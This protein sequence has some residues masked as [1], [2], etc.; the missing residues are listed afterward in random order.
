MSAL[1]APYIAPVV[2]LWECDTGFAE[3]ISPD[4]AAW[5]AAAD[6][7]IAHE[8][9]REVTL[10]VCPEIEFGRVVT[11]HSISTDAYGTVYPRTAERVVAIPWTVAIDVKLFT[12][13]RFVG[14]HKWLSP[15]RSIRAQL[16]RANVDDAALTHLYRLRWPSVVNWFHY[17][18]A[19]SGGWRPDIR[20]R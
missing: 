4:P 9:V 1:F 18:V 5:V 11:A 19:T 13:V 6:N 2:S 8:P 7:V 3:A 15:V 14:D 12:L 16:A 20:I 17:A 10:A